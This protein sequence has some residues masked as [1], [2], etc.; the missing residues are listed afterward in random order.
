MIAAADQR[1]HV[2]AHHTVKNRRLV[3]AQ[4][5]AVTMSKAAACNRIDFMLPKSILGFNLE[6]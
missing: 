1:L 2:S 6:H 4:C 3:A 5:T